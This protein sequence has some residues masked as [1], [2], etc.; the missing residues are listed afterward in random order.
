LHVAI[1]QHRLF[2]SQQQAHGAATVQ[3]VCWGLSANLAAAL[4]LLLHAGA[5]KVDRANYTQPHGF[6]PFGFNN[7]VK[8]ASSVFFA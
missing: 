1:R 5:T 3:S 4:L 8:A 2:S 7:V 6:M